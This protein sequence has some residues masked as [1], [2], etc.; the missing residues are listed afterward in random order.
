MYIV[1]RTFRD[2]NGVFSVGSVVEPTDV[3]AFKSRVQQRHIINIDEQNVDKWSQYFINRH[4]IDL[5]EKLAQIASGEKENSPVV[6]DVTPNSVTVVKDH[7]SQ[8][9]AT[10]IEDVVNETVG[11]Q[12]VL[13]PENSTLD[14]E[15]SGSTP[16]AW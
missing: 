15:Q 14:S 1:T 8:E 4:G 10:I 5:S 3:K 6:N 12:T 2:A 16:D 11:E 9:V 7:E 13:E